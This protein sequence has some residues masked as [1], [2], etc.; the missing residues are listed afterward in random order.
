M[1]KLNK[2]IEIVCSATTYLSSMSQASRDAVLEVLSKHY[3]KV[4]IT[5]VNNLS[6]LEALVATRPDLVFLGMKFVPTDQALGM[7]DPKKIW[8]AKYLDD[9]GIA[10]TGSDH[11]AHELELNKPMAKQRV[12]QAGLKTAPSF[13]AAQSKLLRS[14]DVTLAYPV[15]IKPTNRGGGLGIDSDS[16]AHNYEQL[17]AKVNAIAT[18]LGSD[19]LVEEYLPG[20]EFSVA[21]LKDELSGEFALMPL[22]L[23]AP[24]DERGERLLSEAVKSSDTETAIRVTD[25]AVK[26]KITSLAIN[27]FYA[28]GAREY[29][30]VDIRLDKSG[31]PHFLEANLLP[32]LIRGYGN[33]PKACFLNGGLDFEPMILSIVRLA[34]VRDVKVIE[35]I[36]IF[37]TILPSLKL[38]P[39]PAPVVA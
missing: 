28:L 17:K 37:S 23:I 36:P 5:I 32:S 20:R 21:I 6:D 22:E 24:L 2:H 10:N 13:V 1:K 19:S 9:Y 25:E 26:S 30:R 29:G 7:E 16:V 12:T 39:D 31:I 11:F 8:I 4:G 15:F 3:A 14:E 18:N 33:F 27:A 34:L 38:I 35:D